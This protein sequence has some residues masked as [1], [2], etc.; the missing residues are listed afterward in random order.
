VLTVANFNM[1]CGMDGW[2]RPFDYLAACR[3]LEADVI[4]LEET[5]IPLP[6]DGTDDPAGTAKGQPQEIA[7][8]LGYQVVCC[9]M[10]NGYRIRQ[11][12]DAD[13]RWQ[14]RA[15]FLDR[16]KSLYFDVVRPIAEATRQ[17][18]RFLD[19]EHGTFGI[20]VLVRPDL[21][22][23]DWR[24]ISLPTLARDRVN[25]GAAVVD[26]T[27]EGTPLSVVG[28]HMAHLH[29]G[30]HRHFRLLQERLATEARPTAILSGDMNLWG[31]GVRHFFR[32]WR[33]AV[34]GASWPTWHPHSQIDHILVRG[35]LTA[36]SGE[37]FPDAGSDHRPVRARLNLG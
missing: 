23:E 8:D 19:T 1:H 26:L 31:P 32:G 17:S 18:K 27:V 12:P 6:G 36:A 13:G 22:I 5:W 37:V 33:Q 35:K 11:Q 28:T 14:P 9:P 2:G 21:P 25:R 24:L 10:A 7:A 3:S 30:S 20:A 34:R 16:S 15:S 4:V 29:Q